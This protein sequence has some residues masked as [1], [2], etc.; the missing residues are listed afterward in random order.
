MQFHMGSWNV[1]TEIT[2]L[3]DNTQKV[4]TNSPLS[5]LFMCPTGMGQIYWGSWVGVWMTH[6]YF[7][8]LIIQKSL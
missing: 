7:I 3:S 2:S 4:Q 1:W 8:N 6:K 5:L